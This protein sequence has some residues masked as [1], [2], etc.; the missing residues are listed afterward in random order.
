MGRGSFN[1]DWNHGYPHEWPN[2]EAFH[3]WRRNE[4]SAHTIEL[5]IAKTEYGTK[6]L[7]RTLW[8]I[9][10]VYR[11]TRQRIG[12]KADQKKNPERQQKVP[13]KGTGCNC[14]IIIKLYLHTPIVLG[15]YATEHNHELGESN[16]M[17]TCLLDGARQQIRSLL[18][19]KVAAQEIVRINQSDRQ[20]GSDHPNRSR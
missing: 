1:S 2:L 20:A 19:Q 10:Y 7:G 4:E 8:T 17:Y 11:C 3:E 9:K 6:T 14:Q 5:R 12:Q 18:I 16:I 13:R 15:R